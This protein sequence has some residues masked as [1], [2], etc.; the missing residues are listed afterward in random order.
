MSLYPQIILKLLVLLN[1]GYFLQNLCTPS[2]QKVSDNVVN[3]FGVNRVPAYPRE[4]GDD[5]LVENQTSSEQK[6][7]DNVV[8]AFGMNR[9]NPEYPRSKSGN[10]LVEN[11]FREMKKKHDKMLKRIQTRRK[12]VFNWFRHWD[13]KELKEVF[14][15]NF[16]RLLAF[17]YSLLREIPKENV[18]WRV[19]MTVCMNELKKF[20]G[21]V[22]KAVDQSVSKAVDQTFYPTSLAKQSSPTSSPKYRSNLNYFAWKGSNFA[23]ILTEVAKLNTWVVTE[24]AKLNINNVVRPLVITEVA[25]LERHEK[26]RV[27]PT[28]KRNLQILISNLVT[29]IA[30]ASSRVKYGDHSKFDIYYTSSRVYTAFDAIAFI[31]PAYAALKKLNQTLKCQRLACWVEYFSHQLNLCKSKAS[32]EKMNL[33]LKLSSLWTATKIESLDKSECKSGLDKSECKEKSRTISITILGTIHQKPVLVTEAEM[34]KIATR[35]LD[36]ALE[37]VYSTMFFL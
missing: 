15:G 13:E 32:N 12:S 34:E 31:T 23:D 2:E 8:N 37:K 21:R 33:A 3:A 25:K 18:M 14:P 10:V 4:S 7:S 24:V 29:K 5:V 36:V 27:N 1:T 30:E 26:S 35:A 17:T 20:F 22:S 28:Y 19:R 9:A 11:Q 16:S 6:V